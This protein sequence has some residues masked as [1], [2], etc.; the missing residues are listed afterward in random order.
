MPE[1]PNYYK[2]KEFKIDKL[3]EM[4]EEPGTVLRIEHVLSK[5]KMTKKSLKTHCWVLR[6]RRRTRPDRI[7]DLRLHDGV[8]ERV[9]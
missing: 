7:I 2:P 9:D 4:F 8:I 5:L 3:I 6:D 1:L